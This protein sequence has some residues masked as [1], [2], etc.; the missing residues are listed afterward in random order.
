MK[1]MLFSIIL[2]IGSVVSVLALTNHFTLN[3]NEFSFSE[4]NKKEMVTSNFNE[5]YALKTSINS[6]DEATENTIKEV[7]KK[8]TSLL[9]GN[10]NN[11]KETNLDF[12]QRKKE[13]YNLAATYYYPKDEN[14]KS[15]YDETKDSYRY[16]MVSELAIPLFLAFNDLDISYNTFGDIRIT[17]MD[18]IAISTETIPD[19]IINTE[20]EENPSEFKREK[21]NLII[22]YYFVNIN[23]KYYIGNLYGETKEQIDEYINTIEEEEKSKEM[24]ISPAFKT[25]ILS[26][27]DFSKL[28]SMTTE[29]FQN[30]YDKNINNLVFLNSYYNN[31]IVTEANGFFINDGLIVTT[32]NFIENSLINAQYITINDCNLNIYEMEGLVTANPETDVAIIKVKNK[33]ENHVQIADV[34]KVQ[35]EDPA[36]T[37][38]SKLGVGSSIQKGIIVSNSNYIQSS[39][40]LSQK[41]EGSPLFNKDGDVIGINTSKST[42]SSLSIAVKSDVL[43]EIQNKFNLINYDDIETISFN[44]LKENFYYKKIKKESIINNVSK[45]KLTKYLKIGDIENAIK[46]NIVKSSYQD[47]I[48]SLRYKNDIPNFIDTMQLANKFKENLIKEGYKI[49]VNNSDKTIYKN[50]DYEIIIMK[51]FDYLIIV[52]VKL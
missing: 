32:W 30:I 50:K 28:D 38:S 11:E 52:M 5:K 44:K 9:L 8:A 2:I 41:D 15:G 23:G 24:A 13:F 3:P 45:K 1:K 43:L 47:G 21:T 31:S 17:I 34:T 26:T 37:L 42:N 27:Y 14:S 48:L 49:V 35:K 22:T 25:E 51:E 4:N 7:T 33:T 20:D 40:P 18:D 46:L 6:N 29:D 36:I 19:V 10:F 39:I 16:A 12:Y